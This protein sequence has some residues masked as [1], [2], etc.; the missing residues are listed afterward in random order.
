AR[1]TG[2]VLRSTAG[3]AGRASDVLRDQLRPQLSAMPAL[4]EASQRIITA[5]EAGTPVDP[6]PTEVQAVPP[7]MQLFRPSVQPYL[8][9]WLKYT[10]SKELAALSLPVLILQGTTD[11]QVSVDEANA[12]KAAKPDAELIVVEGMNH[13]MKLPPP[14]RCRNAPPYAT[15]NL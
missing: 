6:L 7:L 1:G 3:A 8:I 5:L 2:C 13:V 4:W 15:P 11:I 12:L 9:S 10:P 14:D